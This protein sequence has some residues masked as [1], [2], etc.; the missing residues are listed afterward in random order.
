MAVGVGSCQIAETRTG[1][2]R[3]PDGLGQTRISQVAGLAKRSIQA[4]L[5]A[6]PIRIATHHV[7][8]VFSYG[9][10]GLRGF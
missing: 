7:R 10:M 9:P 4:L 1:G 2:M 5:P 8:A 3:D 6:D